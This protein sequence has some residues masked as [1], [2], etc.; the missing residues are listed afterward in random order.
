MNKGEANFLLNKISFDLSKKIQV[1]YDCSW[2]LN[3]YDICLHF[4]KL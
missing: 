2:G 3:S 1:N 4:N